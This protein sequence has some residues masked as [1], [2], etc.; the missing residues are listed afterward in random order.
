MPDA[1]FFARKMHE[2]KESPISSLMSLFVPPLR[3]DFPAS[4]NKFGQAHAKPTFINLKS[5]SV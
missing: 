3:N 1:H 5:R 4:D 2:V